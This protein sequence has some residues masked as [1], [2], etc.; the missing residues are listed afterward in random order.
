MDRY[1][2]VTDLPHAHLE[3][4]TALL[5]GD[6]RRQIVAGAE[7]EVPNWETFRV[8]GPFEKFTGRGEICFEYQASVAC[9]RVRDLV[10][11]LV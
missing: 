4:A 8:I 7:L 5:R 10:A 11:V 2:A 6:L 3:H 1:R 9:R